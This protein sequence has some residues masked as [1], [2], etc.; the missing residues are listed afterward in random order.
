M[1]LLVPV[2]A[3]TNTFVQYIKNTSNRRYNE[4]LQRNDKYT[5]YNN[6]NAYKGNNR[7]NKGIEI[8]K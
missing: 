7:Q 4:I 8:Y 6:K 5:T 1:L 2:K 3:L